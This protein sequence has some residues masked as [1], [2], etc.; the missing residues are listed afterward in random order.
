MTYKNADEVKQDH[1][2]KLG[3]EFGEIYNALNNE[4]IWVNLKWQKFVGLFGENEKRI[5]ILNKSAPRFFWVVQGALWDDTL[6]HLCRLTDPPQSV[7]RDNLTIQLL[8][9]FIKE[10]NFR[11]DIEKLITKAV[12]TV[13]FARDWRNRLIA[14]KDLLLKLEM[15]VEPLKPASRLKV[16]LAIEAICNVI[17]EISIH[18]F[19]ASVLF[20]PFEQPGGVRDLLIHLNRSVLFEEKRNQRIRN[21]QFLP[22]DLH[23]EA[24]EID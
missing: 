2:A 9:R 18:Y 13:D 24:V 6:L 11:D 19:D 8:P 20:Q 23:D 7:G 15:N 22:E 1:V 14:H 3:K 10:I 16:R 21:H 4:C 17:N 12:N 5:T